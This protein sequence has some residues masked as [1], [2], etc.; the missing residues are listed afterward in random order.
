MTSAERGM[1]L[2]RAVLRQTRPYRI[3]NTD[4]ERTCVR[5]RGRFDIDIIEWVYV[6][7]RNECGGQYVCMCAAC[8]EKRNPW[9][10]KQGT[11]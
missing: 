2:A 11:A 4:Q 6:N 3:K 1:A 10:F 8:K 7:H 9:W 5:C